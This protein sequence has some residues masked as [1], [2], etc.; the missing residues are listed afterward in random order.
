MGFIMCNVICTSSSL[1]LLETISSNVIKLCIISLVSEIH[2]YLYWLQVVRS[3]LNVYQMIF[4]L[5]LA[6]NL[7]IPSRRGKEVVLFSILL[8]FSLLL[9]QRFAALMR[10][11]EEKI[12]VPGDLL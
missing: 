3:F 8:P 11:Q 6:R 7:L 12:L 5:V 10:V 2:K 1:H 4:F 9:I